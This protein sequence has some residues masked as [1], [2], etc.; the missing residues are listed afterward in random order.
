MARF[1]AGLTQAHRLPGRPSCIPGGYARKG[2][3]A[4]GLRY[5][6]TVAL[7][8][9]GLHGIWFSYVDANGLGYCQPDVLLGMDGE[10]IILECKLT[11]VDDARKQLAHLYL[12]V[13]A[14][15]TGRPTRGIVVTRHLT[16]ETNPSNVCSSLGEALKRAT[17]DY[18][19]TLHWIGRGP[20]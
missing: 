11:E 5:E 14:K 10:L 18:A 20:I 19:P 1:V 17:S 3:K 4:Y 7:R 8:T 15:A 9:G 2:A 12:P 16:R 6:R 13:V